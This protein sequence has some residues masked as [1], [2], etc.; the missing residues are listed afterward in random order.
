MKKEEVNAPDSLILQ[1][2]KI[3]LIPELYIKIERMR[4]KMSIQSV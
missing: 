3:D 2:Q 4:Q 1:Q